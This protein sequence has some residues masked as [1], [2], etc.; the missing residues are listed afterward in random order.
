MAV[1]WSNSADWVL[2]RCRRRFWF[3][4]IYASP[5]AKWGSPRREAYILSN[6]RTLEAWRGNLVHTVI[7]DYVVPHLQQGEIP[8]EADLQAFALDR[9]RRQLKF[10]SI[11]KY[12]ET[13]MTKTKGGDSYAAI[14]EDE[15]E[16]TASRLTKTEALAEIRLALVNLWKLT[17]LLDELCES[18]WS[19]PEALLCLREFEIP[20]QG[21][22]DLMAACAGPS[23]EL[24]LIDWK[25]DRE[26]RHD[27]APQLWL[28]AYL[29]DRT[30]RYQD[31]SYRYQN[32]PEWVKALPKSLLEVNLLHGSIDES[33]WGDRKVRGVEDRI[34]RGIRTIQALVDGRKP[35][36]IHGGELHVTDNPNNCNYCPFRQPCQ[37]L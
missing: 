6:A 4:Y 30:D 23:P 12:G 34:F 18:S 16:S 27:Y 13:G 14:W 32:I 24:K 29:L 21:R 7:Q 15:F 17:E 28:Y 3:Q 25:L 33:E 9:A 8:F 26:Q 2:R 5:R 36:Q 35:E 31:G 22:I 10:S 37:A 11:K 19:V 20:I 1:Q